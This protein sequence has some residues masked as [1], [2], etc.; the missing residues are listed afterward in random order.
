RHQAE[1]PAAMCEKTVHLQQRSKALQERLM[2]SEAT[3]QAQAEQLKDYRELLS[4]SYFL[5]YREF[6]TL[7]QA[8]ARELSHLRQRLRDGRSVCSILTQHLGDTT[9]S[10][11]ELLR[12]NDVDFYMGQSFREQ[13][14]QSSALAQR[15]ATKISGRESFT[16]SPLEHDKSGANVF[17]V[18]FLT[19]DLS[20]DPEKTELLAIRSVFPPPLRVD[21][22][23]VVISGKYWCM[24]LIHV[25]SLGQNYQTLAL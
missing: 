21:M 18:C 10:F 20:E 1:Q 25:C 15:V 13:L 3:V 23:S 5:L 11:E 16:V 8:Q 17:F 7:I 24:T 12:A 6:D 4:E 2:V 19:G 22:Q 14:A 9:K